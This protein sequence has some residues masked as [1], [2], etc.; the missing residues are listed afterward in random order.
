MW[1]LTGVNIGRVW[2]SCISTSTQSH[3]TNPHLPWRKWNREDIQIQTNHFFGGVLS[4]RVLSERWCVRDC[5][6][7]F[8]IRSTVSCCRLE[9]TSPE[10]SSCLRWRP[11]EPAG[12]GSRR[13]Q[14]GETVPASSHILHVVTFHWSC[15]IWLRYPQSQTSEQSRGL[16]EPPS[17]I[18]SCESSHWLLS[19]TLH[20]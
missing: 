12:A 4:K 10:E 8:P 17:L 2:V 15:Y 6:E 16:Q 1:G 3:W 9:Q 5:L 18:L 11:E 19:T 13:Q 7:V 14:T 20:L